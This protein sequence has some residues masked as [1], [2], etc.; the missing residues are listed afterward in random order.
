L[1]LGAVKNALGLPKFSSRML[2]IVI[3]KQTLS[4][5]HQPKWNKAKIT[6]SDLPDGVCMLGA[7]N[8][9]PPQKEIRLFSKSRHLCSDL[10]S[11]LKAHTIMEA[12]F[13]KVWIRDGLLVI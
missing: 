9:M 7:D 5:L 4:H 1:G 10:R 2:L 11:S 3:K 13:T 12:M 8:D 6:P